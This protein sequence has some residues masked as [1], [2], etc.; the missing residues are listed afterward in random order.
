[1][2]RLTLLLPV[3]LVASVLGALPLPSAQAAT[4]AYQPGLPVNMAVFYAT[5]VKQ[6]SKVHPNKPVD[7]HDA[8]VIRNQIADMQY[9]GQ[10]VGLYSWFG[11]NSFP[12]QVFPTHLRAADDST[13]RWAVLNEDEGQGKNPSSSAAKAD[14]DWIYSRYGQDPSYYRI[15]GKPVMFLYG[16]AGDTCNAAAR[17]EAA[18]SAHR[19][20]IVMKAVSGYTGCRPQPQGWYG[21]APANGHWAQGN[22]FAV[23]PGFNKVGESSARLGRSV[24]RFASDVRAMKASKTRFHITTTWNEWTESTGVEQATEWASRSGHGAYVDQMHSILGSAVAPPAPP[25]A[26]NATTSAQGVDLSWSASA[27]ATAYQVYRNGCLLKDDVAGTTYTDASGL[28]NESASYFVKAKSF[29]GTSRRG[30]VRIGSAGTVTPAPVSNGRDGLVALAGER[31]FSTST[32][33]GVGCA[34]RQRGQAVFTL[35]SSVPA[36]ATGAVLVVHA[37]NALGN[38]AVQLFPAG[39]AASGSQLRYYSSRASSNTTLVQIGTSRQVVV[40]QSGAATHLWIDVIGYAAPGENGL[41]VTTTSPPDRVFYNSASGSST[42][43]GVSGPVSGTHTFALPSGPA[44]ATAAQVR[45]QVSGAAAPGTIN[46]YNGSSAPPVASLAFD[47]SVILTNSVL[48]PVTGGHTVTFT[49]STSAKVVLALEGWVQPQGQGLTVRKPASLVASTTRLTAK[50]IQLPD[51]FKGHAVLLSIGVASALGYG[52]LTVAPDGK[53]PQVQT[54]SYGPQQPQSGF[55]WVYCPANGI[56]HVTL[57]PKAGA[58]LAVDLLG[59]A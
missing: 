47:K 41:D 4:A 12:D 13:F 9:G 29:R 11:R 17:W 31:V 14:L 55:V 34:A 57:S 35:P 21:Y 36:N 19:F 54:V 32:G 25:G 10:Q 52:N 7:Y 27:G 58:L 48:V 20:F 5:Q 43:G 46:V 1:M 51:A 59:D 49:V 23:S 33:A 39:G 42:L 26:L 56:I 3:L 16:D 24:S 53:T 8:E 45:V 37:L 38:G 18:D 44:G 28:A 40:Q 15:G 2:K 22:S 30:P 6:A 50:D